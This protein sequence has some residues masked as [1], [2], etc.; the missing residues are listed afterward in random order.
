MCVLWFHIFWQSMVPLVVFRSVCMYTY[1][2]TKYSSQK[3]QKSTPSHAVPFHNWHRISFFFW[4]YYNWKR[5][6]QSAIFDRLR[7]RS[8]EFGKWKKEQKIVKWMHEMRDYHKYIPIQR[9]YW[10]GETEWKNRNEWND[11]PHKHIGVYTNTH[12]IGSDLIQI[13]VRLSNR[14]KRNFGCMWNTR[15][16]AMQTLL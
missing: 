3:K 13:W 5:L 8:N 14:Y 9:E 10:N 7:S 1:A 11:E 16:T 4:V 15:C 6:Q 12:G 2:E